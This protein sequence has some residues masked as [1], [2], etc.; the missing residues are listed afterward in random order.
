MRNQFQSGV[1]AAVFFLSL[2]S[3]L[4][5]QNITEKNWFF[6]NSQQNL[7]FDKSGR[8]VVLED[9]QSIAF[10]FGVG[11][12][13]V[14]NDQFT[15][16]LLFYSDGLRVYDAN[17]NLLPG[18]F[19]SSLSGNTS[20]NQ[21]VVTC[22]VPG[23]LEQYYIFT[24]SDTAINYSTIDASL[25][26]I[27]TNARFPLGNLTGTTNNSMALPN[28]SE[29]M[30]IIEA[31]DG[32]N[33]WLISQNRATYELNLTNITSS[34][35]VTRDTT[36]F[37]GTLPGFEVNQ[38]GIYY[39]N[40]DSVDIAMAPKDANRNVLLVNFKPSTGQIVFKNSFRSSGG[41]DEIYDVE[42]SND[43]TKLYYSVLGDVTDVGGVFQIDLS[44]T[45]NTDPYL[46]RDVLQST[47]YRSYGLRRGIDGRIYHLYQSAP[48]APFNLGRLEFV[49]EISLLVVY[50]DLVFDDDFNGTQF[51]AFA[52][53]QLAALTVNFDW[54]DDCQGLVTQFFADVD[55]E[56]NNYFWIFGDGSQSNAVAPLKTY[57]AAGSY[58]VTL[59]TELNG[60]I[61]FFD[62]LV[63]IIAIDSADLGNDTTICQGSGYDLDPGLSAS[64]FTFVWNTGAITPTLAVNPD[65]T[66]IYWVNAT[67]IAAPNCTTYDDIEVTVYLSEP[68]PPSSQW[69][70]GEEAAIDFTNG[71]PVA[72]YDNVM[73]SP[74]GCASI[75]DINGDLLFYTNGSTVWNKEHK[76]MVNGTKIGGDS[77]AA[78]SAL[79]I[80]FADDDT[81]F[82][83][84][85]TEKVYGDD[86]IRLKYSIVD[87]KEDTARGE[88]V[89]K[90]V[91][92][93]NSSTERVTASGFDSPFLLTH[94]FG[95]NNFRVYSI[96]ADGI[97]AASHS[98]IGEPHRKE[99]ESNQSGY[100][101]FSP[102]VSDLSVVIPGDP[103]YLEIF[104]Y[105]FFNGAVTNPRL[106]DLQEA[107][108]TLAYG[109]EYS[110]NGQKL[111]V[112][113]TGAGSKI[114]QYS[115]DSLYATTAA[116]DIE[117]TKVTIPQSVVGD[118]GALQMGPDGV[119]YLAIDNQT[120]LGSIVGSSALGAEL[121]AA[122]L[123]LDDGSGRQSRKGLPNFIQSGGTGSQ[124]SISA[125]IACVGQE[126]TFSGS[127]L[128]PNQMVENFI[129]DFGD[130]GPSLGI[131]ESP[132]TSHVYLTPISTTAT[133]YIINDCNTD[134]I[135]LTV[136]IQAFS[137]PE[138]PDIPD[139]LALCGGI[140][141]VE[142]WP[143]D[144]PGLHYWWSTGDTTRTVTFTEPSEF[145]LAIFNNDGCASD[146]LQRFI[147][148]GLSFI[149]LGEDFSL[150]QG[151]AG[152][153]LA[154]GLPNSTFV[155]RR[156][157]VIIGDLNSQEVSTSRSG[158]FVYSVEATNQFSNCIA[159]D[160][161]VV[162]ILTEPDLEQTNIIQPDCGEANGS[163]QIQFSDVGNYSYE[164]T[165]DNPA[166]P[167]TFDG[168][169]ETP[170]LENLAAGVYV[171]N[172][173]NTVTGCINVEVFLLEDDAEFEMEAISENDCFRSGDIRVVLR[174]FL[175]SRVD[176]T[177]TNS[178]A[179]TIYFEENRSASNIHIED[180][181]TGL[182]Y[183]SARQVVEP[184][185]L[186]TDTV[187]LIAE[188][189]CFRTIA[190]PNA[191]SPN[192]NGM[193]EEFF[194]FPNEF[195]NAFEIFIYNRWGQIVYNSKDVNFRWDG[196]F[197]NQP[198]PPTTY[199]YKMIFTSTLEPE[200]G[201][202]IQYGSITLIR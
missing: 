58:N 126:T 105:N 80:P 11:G 178:N 63:N 191:F 106:I 173:T 199:A 184:Q 186:Q 141:T 49:D 95:N 132:D 24:N 181:D 202:I 140:L 147:G 109:L 43:G 12:S 124:A 51:P 174:N 87:I 36:V 175:G 99:N 115:L 75:S 192:G 142:A 133:L 194:V 56:P 130:G 134:T 13:A 81:F 91:T 2:I 23:S 18:I 54:I 128:D 145:R 160:S 46:V 72:L 170:A 71:A 47:P 14:I 76:V 96:S 125:T 65:T 40:N 122:N 101:K 5:A 188:L 38:F 70:F 7:V 33:Y 93:V 180:L 183:V 198:A 137:I 88:V 107:A 4:S 44:D 34:G 159:I 127:G 144:T 114:L 120:D 57:G 27:S 103:N 94:E 138:Q 35:F 102:L 162:T 86:S 83:I 15:G 73:T 187:H 30:A 42:W 50:N 176:I 196:R 68:L 158:T 111:Y 61:G 164:L 151:D 22:P 98:S 172:A 169:G 67:Q 59:V 166:G 89:K 20:F 6:G 78:Q 165:G 9:D 52:P 62:Q 79:I 119:I 123:L 150:C 29:G 53:P 168:P 77:T 146:T 55:P 121:T 195:I 17:H 179:E 182:Y 37:S 108:P 39:H 92:L 117:A 148:D 129:W 32:I 185:C 201:E 25:P 10:G 104:D 90:D 143:A 60:R 85:T 197:Q 48:N 153:I 112:S 26:G 189:K 149:D 156:D 161:V 31:G 110:S 171:L 200:I 82:Y 131:L 66:R 177:V 21:A 84:F 19:S 139:P 163:F 45:I 113:M 41:S 193:N 136:P 116:V 97:S 64:E 74:D 152:P 167:F 135:V 3:S 157:S 100:M 28:Q 1:V 154:A 8:E 16:D 155:W 190:A 118:F 69:Y